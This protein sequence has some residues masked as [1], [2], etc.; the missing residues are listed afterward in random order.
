MY[1]FSFPF[2][3]FFM[4]ETLNAKA[5][6]DSR[7]TKSI[8]Q[9]RLIRNRSQAGR[10]LALAKEFCFGREGSHFP[11]GKSSKTPSL[12][13]KLVHSQH[14]IFHVIF[15]ALAKEFC[16]GR[17]G[18]HFPCGKNSKTPKSIVRFNFEFFVKSVKIGVSG[19][20]HFLCGKSSKTPK[21]I[22]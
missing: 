4:S 6:Q 18:S 22:V 14:K 16:F 3:L 19:G 11:C 8:A 7:R 1:I 17:E 10:K 5:F 21:S 15:I 20:S 12:I 13:V 9:K 2:R